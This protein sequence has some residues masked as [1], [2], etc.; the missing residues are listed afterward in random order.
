M[1]AHVYCYAEHMGEVKQ[2]RLITVE[3]VFEVSGRGI[4]PVPAVPY[5]LMK[6]DVGEEL[7]VG[8][9]LELRKPNET[10]MRVKLCGLGRFSP[11]KGGLGLVLSPTL[12]KA[13]VPIGTEIWTV[14]K[15]G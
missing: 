14:G 8:D 11:D 4:C 10:L 7:K 5:A 13:D 6:S 1:R 3:D 15:P 9:T 2:R 12:S